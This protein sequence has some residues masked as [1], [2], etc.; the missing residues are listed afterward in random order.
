MKKAELEKYI[1]DNYTAEADRPWAKFPN[2]QVFRHSNNK[3]WFALIA[4]I[5]KNRLGM[6][7]SDILDVVNLKCDPLLIGSLRDENGFFPAYHMSKEHWITAAL[8]GS[9]PDE[10]IKMLIGMS[11]DATAAKVK[12]K[13]S[14]E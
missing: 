13:P 11:F 7:S 5:P 9:A 2:Y 3:K 8:D 6:E 12:R 10:T 1:L 14:A 4:D